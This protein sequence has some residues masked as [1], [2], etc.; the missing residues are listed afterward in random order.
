MGI[1]RFPGPVCQ[2][3]RS[4]EIEDGTLARM[5]S[6]I[7]VQNGLIGFQEEGP[8]VAMGACS[9]LN[10]VL[11]G[12]VSAPGQPLIVC[13]PIVVPPESRPYSVSMDTPGA[14][15]RHLRQKGKRFT[16]TVRRS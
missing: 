3:W 12:T 4:Y 16:S 10:P 6:P 5:P 13:V 8:V 15:V 1:F 9:F 7:P 2:T 11:S 14:T